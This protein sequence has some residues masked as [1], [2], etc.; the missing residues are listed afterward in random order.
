MR[1]APSKSSARISYTAEAMPASESDL[2]DKQIFE[3]LHQELHRIARAKMRGERPDHTLQ[4]TALVNE[5][6]LKLFRA[7]LPSDLKCELSC[8]KTCL[9][10]VG[11]CTGGR[12]CEGAIRYIAVVKTN[13]AG[14]SFC[15][16]TKLQLTHVEFLRKQIGAFAVKEVSVRVFTFRR[17]TGDSFDV[18]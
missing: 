2:S 10:T 1:L 8:C 18:V 15:L 7:R 11:E 13:A 3:S 4:A 5:V 6:F 16:A 9:R 14:D 17:D 12:D